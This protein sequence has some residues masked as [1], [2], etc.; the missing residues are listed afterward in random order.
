MVKTIALFEIRNGF[1]RLSTYIYFA[2]F[3]G[4]GYLIF[5]VAAGAFPG[6][7][8]GLGAGGKLYANSAFMLFAL[9]S[10]TS[11]Y[12]LLVV[13]AV[14][15][16]A[17]H[18][19]F[20]HNTFPLVF[21]AP[22]SK[23]QYLGG[24][25]LA[26]NVILLFIFSSIGI[27]CF[28]AGLTATVDEKLIGPFHLFAYLQPYL[29]VVIPNTFFVG[30][31]FFAVAALSRNMLPVYVSA[32][33]LF[34]GYLIAAVL[35]TQLDSK[36]VA[37]V[38]DPFGNFALEHVTQ[39][40]TV[41]EKNSESIPM[42][43]LLLVNRLIWTSAGIGVLGLT[44]WLFR[45]Q[46]GGEDRRQF[47]ESS[48]GGS[49]VRQVALPVAAVRVTSQVAFLPQLIWLEFRGI[50]ASIPFLLI[51]ICG[52]GFVFVSSISLQ[53]M[54]GTSIHPVTAVVAELAR[55]SFTLF[56]MIVIIVYSGQLVWREREAGM[57][58][59]FDVQPT[60]TWLPF[61][62]KTA[63]LI[64][65]QALLLLVVMFAGMVIQTAQGYFN[66]ELGVY[67][68]DLFGIQIVN[69]A[70][71]SILAMFV[72]VLVN[73]KY[74][75]HFVMVLYFLGNVFLANMGWSHHLY[76]Y[77]TGPGYTYSDMNGFGHFMIASSWFQVYWALFA[78][79]LAVVCKLL[80]V[81]GLDTAFVARAKEARARVN[82]VTVAIV[83][84]TLVPFVAVGGFIFYNTNVLNTY[85]T[86]SDRQSMSAQ[87]ERQYKPKQSLA[88]PRITSVKVNVDIHPQ[89]RRIHVQGTYTL[90]NKTDQPIESVLV[91]LMNQDMQV[92]EL[93]IGAEN[94]PAINDS[95]QGVY[96]FE[97]T[98]PLRP[99]QSTVLDFELDFAVEGF[100]NGRGDTQI[101]YNGTFFNSDNLPQIGYVP[102]RELSDDA[103]RRKHGFEPK[104]RMAKIDDLQARANNYISRHADWIDF[105]A[106]VSTSDDQIAVAPG[107][108]QR[109][110]I[111]GDR[112]Y[113]HYKAD[114]RILC[115]FSFLSARYEVLRDSWNDVAI[116][117]YHHPQHKY[118]LDS[119]VG[120]MKASLEYCSENFSP[121]QHKQARIL[122]FPRYQA[123]AQSFPNTIP[124]S[125]SVGFIAKVDPDDEDDIDYPV[126]VTAHEIAHQWW[127]H[128][129]IGGNVQGATMLSE[130]LAQYSALM[131]MKEMFGPK[132]MKRFLRHELDQYLQ[133]RGS[134]RKKELPLALVENQG[135]IHYNKGSLVMYA[136]QDYIGE[137]AVNRALAEFV[138]ET[139]FQEPPYTTSR[140]L[141]EQ[142]RRVTPADLQYLI[143]DLF[144]S[145]TL[146]ENKAVSAT[147]RKL[148]GGDYEVTIDVTSKKVHA[149]EQGAETE[150]ELRD[151]IDIGVLDRRGKY[152]FLE[153]RLIDS[154]ECQFVVTVS[155]IPGKAG[156]DP[157]NK[158]IDRM[159]DDNVVAVKLAATSQ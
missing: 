130:T 53:A 131:V 123:F 33:V 149:D 42:T 99:G 136:L 39:Y 69:V 24:R 70:L 58:Q 111:E 47:R 4:L 44:C 142:I 32:V 67:V 49:A 75:G 10:S 6:V 89:D 55:G 112:R 5:V 71:L 20:R 96:L 40:W 34:V 159:P 30:A 82:G 23:M 13:A 45:M 114:G 63:A 78:V 126:Y 28:V 14:M 27:A 137:E 81:R 125:E 62:S 154:A 25:F 54:Y 108:L 26:A 138:K 107:S 94:E 61:A 21:T 95:D 76:R 105:E 56:M 155:S 128:Q 85:R 109:E 106:V 11:F 91:N 16:N 57:G 152:L 143:D 48:A 2:L 122:E 90:V 12:G 68:R 15:G 31:A 97:L 3:F 92:H 157:L 153:K 119:M 146:F 147:Y 113:Y 120:A 74:L 77:G 121:Y 84:L 38:I 19:D 9:I 127:A 140:E 151:Q 135:Y 88:Q 72:Q 60:S 59:L 7:D 117:I 43:G 37:G 132:K 100:K 17:A 129:V 41:A 103:V 156:I 22:V 104:P 158:L 115:F 35:S 148:D 73:H 116:E 110:W 86:R 8:T 52:V 134:E 118:N 65:V 150:A 93:K 51:V 50:V 66:Y 98:D 139:G 133:G 101:V 18:Q 29:L 79:L 124:Y 145:I 80:W 87:Y 64:L 144:E 36:Y 46:Q 1:Q 141:I 83:V 102:E